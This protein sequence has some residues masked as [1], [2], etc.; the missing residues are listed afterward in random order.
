MLQLA[1]TVNSLFL[2]V[3]SS[4]G[5]ATAVAGVPYIRL[6]LTAFKRFLNE[7]SV[8][9]KNIF[10]SRLRPRRDDVRLRLRAHP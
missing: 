7:V 9:F 2:P 4:V 8:S 1:G 5:V 6:L 3:V 10:R